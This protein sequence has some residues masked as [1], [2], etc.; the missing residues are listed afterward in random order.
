[1]EAALPQTE[2]LAT[3]GGDIL[4]IGSDEAIMA[5][6]GPQTQVI[7]LDGRAL[8]P[9]FIDPHQH[10][11]PNVWLGNRPEFP[12][13]E[14]AQQWMLE[15]GET[16]VGVP[17]M[18]PESLEHFLA[19]AEQ[20]G[21][22]RVRTSLYLSYNDPCGVRRLPENWYAAYPPV[23]E[24]GEMVRRP[25]I[26]I[27]ADGG[28]CLRPAF[29]IDLLPHMVER[30][31]QGD[32][33]FT[34]AELAPIIR[35]LQETGYQV[36]IHAFG[37]RGVE[38]VQD[39]L[40]AA[41]DGQPDTYR[42]R[43]EH[44][45]FIRPESLSR[46]GELGIVPVVFG[47]QLTCRIVNGVGFAGQLEE[48]QPWFRPFRS[49]IDANPGLRIAWKSDAPG[50]GTW[51]LRELSWLVTR[52]G[53]R[54]DGTVCEPPEWLRAEAITVEEALQ[55]MTINAAHAL[56]MGGATGSLKP[57]KFADFVILSDNP[58][59]VEPDALIDLEVLVTMVGG[60][61]EYCSPSS[62][63]LCPAPYVWR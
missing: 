9:G 4:A 54:L 42:H 17:G 53:F 40:E 1:M 63:A 22:L 48:A 21:N 55:F 16:M 12:S 26:K 56:L 47:S 59:T 31:P 32:L 23:L 35:G 14:I 38:T 25:G 62:E 43:M 46:Y 60:R 11:F 29:S 15:R 34:A 5:L 58:L 41:L 3:L 44:N 37:D 57:G 52:K 51:P 39:A 24:T 10:V 8:L 7:D 6:H 36:A 28:A 18:R 2:A 50:H 61:S 19:F 45:E 13:Y 20:D 33:Y 27:W 49:L 30:G